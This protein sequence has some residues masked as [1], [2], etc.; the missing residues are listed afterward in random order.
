MKIRYTITYVSLSYLN[1]PFHN[2]IKQYYQLILFRRASY[3]F[4]VIEMF[5]FHSGF[6]YLRKISCAFSFFFIYISSC[7]KRLQT[8]LVHKHRLAVLLWLMS[9][10]HS[11]IHAQM[12]REKFNV[13]IDVQRIVYL[14]PVLSFVVSSFTFCFHLLTLWWYLKGIVQSC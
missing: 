9:V 5:I 10:S 3:C 2:I 7:R 11:V 14:Y 13:F 4:I 12:N 8:Q 6:Y 1:I